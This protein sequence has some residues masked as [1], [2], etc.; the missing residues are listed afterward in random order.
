MIVRYRREHTL[1]SS[2]NRAAFIKDTWWKISLAK[3]DVGEVIQ[4][5][6]NS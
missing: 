6:F 1:P 2:N 5:F 4:D 3:F